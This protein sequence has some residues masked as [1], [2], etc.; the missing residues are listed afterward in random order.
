MPETLYGL[1]SLVIALALLAS[2]VIA[3]EVGHRLGRPRH[4]RSD[5][6]T[7]THVN[8]IQSSLLG[9]L[10]LLIGF[11]FSLALQRFDSRSEAVVTEANAIGTAT[12]RAGLLPDDVR[13]D[14]QD[15]L[16]R[17]VDSRIADSTVALSARGARDAAQATTRALME[18][19][20]QQGLVAARANDSPV[21]TGL[22]LSALND[23]FDAW[24][25]RDAELNRHVPEVILLLL[26]VTC[27]LSGGV[28]GYAA[29]LGGHRPSRSTYI[30]VVLLVA[31]AF[32]IV[33]LD[34]PRRG[35]I[36]VDHRPL[37]ELQKSPL[38]QPVPPRS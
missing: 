20:W 26:N 37:F 19:L 4:L 10:A 2:M 28:I 12:L 36:R 8:G 23:M 25:R 35:L 13:A 34:R 17:Y 22:Y 31:I 11:T 1:N 15:L 29:G 27:V 33:D 6:A 21:T 14:S 38:H 30:F 32:V 3:V 7:R 24:G 16:R 9:A 5:D 18:A